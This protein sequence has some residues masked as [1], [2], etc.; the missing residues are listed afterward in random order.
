VG[1]YL[2]EWESAYKRGTCTPM[3]I[4]SLFTI[5]KLWN[6]LR[7]PSTN[8]WIKKMWCKYTMQYYSAIKRIKLYH[9]QENG[10]NWRSSYKQNKPDS[11]RQMFS[12]ICGI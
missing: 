4:V 12:L 10:W 1:I 2:K 7:C 8:K 3:F 5:A 9:L 11:E 6:Q